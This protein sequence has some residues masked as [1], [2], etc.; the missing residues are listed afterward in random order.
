MDVLREHTGCKFQMWLTPQQVVV[1]SISEKCNDCA[2]SGLKFLNNADIRGEVDCRNEKIG[3][4]IRDNELKRIPFLLI[5]GEKEE[6]DGTVS[7][8][9]Q[10]EGDKGTMKLEEFAAYLADLVKK[11]VEA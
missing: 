9:M 11:E 2:Q 1:L 8:R 4:K 5:V 6:A 3:R 7:V 10:G